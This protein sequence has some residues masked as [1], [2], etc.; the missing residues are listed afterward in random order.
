[1]TCYKPKLAKW[2]YANK[3]NEKTGEIHKTKILKFLSWNEITPETPFGENI[4]AIPCG[5]CEGCQVDKANDWSTR[6]ILEASQYKD[7]CFLTLTYDNEHL[8]K[9]SS[10]EK[11][12]I[13]KFMKKLRKK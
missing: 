11:K 13:Q 10:L 7:N 12:E 4:T 2:E 8:P 1:M 9:N 3:I 6:A 5:K